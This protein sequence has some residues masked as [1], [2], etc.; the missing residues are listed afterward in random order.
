MA[1][2]FYFPTIEIAPGSEG[3]GMVDMLA[4]LIRQNLED[5]PDKVVDFFKLRGRVAI[6]AE[7]ADVSLTLEFN[8]GQL[9]VHDGVVGVPDLTVRADS[10]NII[11]MSLI[12]IMDR[13]GLPD[14]FGS[15]NRKIM[16]ATRQQE[17]HVYGALRNIPFLLRF[18]RVMSVN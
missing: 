2:S 8:R 17:I 14:P 1:F 3:K 10:D 18:T 12:E 6:V 5:R 16:S 9:T 7:D 13:S 11:N 15:M 4:N